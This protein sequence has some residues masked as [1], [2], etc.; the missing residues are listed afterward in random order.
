MWSPPAGS[1]CDR[2][3]QKVKVQHP[4]LKMKHMHNT[5]ATTQN[6]QHNSHLYSQLW[7]YKWF[8]CVLRYGLYVTRWICLSNDAFMTLPAVK[9]QFM[10]YVSASVCLTVW[11]YGIM[12]LHLVICRV[13]ALHSSYCTWQCTWKLSPPPPPSLCDQKMIYR[14]WQLSNFDPLHLKKLDWFDLI[15][16]LIWLW[17]QL[18][19][20]AWFF[21]LSRK[22]PF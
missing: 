1:V 2:A 6:H 21:S 10:L 20:A 14:H 4:E 16:E 8:V 22:L 11:I 18:L 5:E 15:S 7:V 3:S 19:K 12:F 17:R 9:Q 13:S